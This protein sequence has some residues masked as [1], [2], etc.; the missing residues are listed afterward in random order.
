MKLL[1]LKKIKLIFVFIFLSLIILK[2][3]NTP[4]NFYSILNWN[5]KDRMDQN[6]GF[7]KNESWGF[8][9]YVI[10][11]FDLK[12][13]EIDIIN[14][15]GYVTLERVF[16]LK[17]TNSKNPKFIIILNFKSKNDENIFNFK[18]DLLKNYKIK[19]RYDNCFLMEIND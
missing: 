3:F 16:N 5:Y 19:Y 13:Y 2:F 14:D 10:N 8:Q 7:C 4:F 15:G 17:K 6:Y 12:N 11:K 18:H 9:N 1:N